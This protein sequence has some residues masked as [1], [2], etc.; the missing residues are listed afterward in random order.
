MSNDNGP[1]P[2]AWETISAGAVQTLGIVGLQKVTR[3][4]PRTGQIGVFDVMHSPDWVNVIAL[5]TDDEILMIEQYRH[6]TG[7]IELEIP[8]G[9]VDPGESPEDAACRELLEETGYAGSRPCLLGVSHPN[10]AFMNNCCSTWLV[11]NAERVAEPSLDP[12]EDIRTIHFPVSEIP[13][14]IG[15]GEITHAVV[16]AAL[17]HWTVKRELSQP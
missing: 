8:G 3:K 10:P 16:I 11:E 1:R 4:S 12:E 9:V 14:L 7:A 2:R 5:T 6:G 17:M 13:N 15:L